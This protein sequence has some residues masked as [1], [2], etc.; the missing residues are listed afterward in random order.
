MAVPI[1]VAS[2]PIETAA[3]RA[4]GF[5]AATVEPFGD[6]EIRTFLDHWVAALH[7]AEA[8]EGLR[9][10]A[11]RYRAD[12]VAAICDLPRVRRLAT[13]PVML[14]CLC[15]V[16]WNEGHLPEGRSRVYRAVLK[17]LIASR[18]E[19]RERAGFTDRF[20]WNAF[21]R[22]GLA[23][24]TAEG[25]KRAVF[26]LEDGAVAVDVAVQR[27]FPGLP[28]EERRRE[29]RRWLRFECLGSGVV[30]EVSGN[31]L[32]FWHLTFQ[33]FLAAL[34]L[35]WLDDQEIAGEDP[36]GSWWPQIRAHLDDAQWR[37][38]VELLPGCLLDEGGEGRV[39]RLLDRVLALRGER[40]D[41]ATEARTAGI[42]GRLLQTLSAY[43][44]RPRPEV[45]QA[46]EEVLGR[47]LA[48]F[49]P[50]G[51]ARVPVKDRI[52]AAEA[53]GRGGDPRLAPERAEEN[54]IKVPRLGGLRL[55][56][57]PVT[58]EE[59]QRFVESRGY[60]EPRFWDAESWARREKAEWEGPGSWEAQLETPNRPVTWV[61]WYEAVA[62]CRWLSEQRGSAVRLPTEAEC[63]K[64]A[65]AEEGKYPWG[66]KQPDPE[67]TNF[68]NYVG[69]PT[70]VG[71][72]PAGD[73]ALG[74]SDLA[75]NVWEWCADDLGTDKDGNT[76]RPLW[77]GGWDYPAMSL[78]AAYRHGNWARRRYGNVGFRVA[79]AP[80]STLNR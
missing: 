27:Q 67:L 10:E 25:G 53:L 7:A 49:R 3:L 46:Y 72:Y 62:Y 52:A 30:E 36:Q 19:A 71:I 5:H 14:T 20:A 75:G 47:S 76:M 29:A 33:E 44:Y 41:L 65:T 58:V 39:D 4:M 43:Q 78:R 64:A 13:N 32:R 28:P 68:G 80:A 9:G 31:R 8:G 15:V 11:A 59:Y 35:A 18:A 60:E 70:P 63:E 42:A 69:A 17:W 12:L 61:S 74:H 66:V 6:A 2:R 22:L 56:K 48:I 40:P 77:G 24:V 34:Q 37:E 51:A 50:E 57:Y 23:M 73:N 16:H 55:G 79:A 38:I 21:A 45:A 54:F 1:V 26:D